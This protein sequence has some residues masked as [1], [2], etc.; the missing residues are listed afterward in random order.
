M[1]RFSSRSI[2]L[3]F[4]SAAIVAM[5]TP[6]SAAEITTGSLIGTVLDAAGK[7]LAKVTVSA[8][9][10]SGNYRTVTNE[11]GEFS[12]L[13][14]TPDTYTLSAELQ[15]YQ[16]GTLAGVNVLTGQVQ[17][18]AFRLTSG[19]RTIGKTRAEARA[20]SIGSTADAFIVTGA[21]AQARSPVSVSS[22]LSTFSAGTVQGS[23]ASAPGI[24]FDGLGNV[25]TRGGKVDDTVFTFDSVPIPQ[26]LTVNPGG[27]FVGAQTPTTGV[28][29][30]SV[31]L[32]GYGNQS[33]NALGGIV[34]Q[35][36]LVGTYPTQTDVELGLGADVLYHFASLQVRTASPDLR[37]R[38]AISTRFDDE[39]FSFGDG[40]SFYPGE[41]SVVGI[42]LQQRGQYSSVLNYHYALGKRDD[43]SFLE[44]NGAASY[45]QYGSPFAG[46]TIGLL[47]GTNADGTTIPFPGST[48]QNAPVT[49]PSRTRGFFN[50]LKAEY[51][52]TSDHSLE[53]LRVYQSFFGAAA[54]GPFWDDNAF[55]QGAVSLVSHNSGHLTGVQF[56]GT[57]TNDRNNVQYGVEHRVDTSILDEFVPTG[58]EAVHS[59]PTLQTT[60]GYF[61]DTWQ[62]TDRLALTGNGRVFTTH[63][64]P[65][66]GFAYDVGA[67]DPHFG[68]SY[69]LG[70]VYALRGTFDHNTVAPKPLETDLTDSTNVLAD[71]TLA[72]FTPLTPERSNDFTYSFEGGGRT[73]FRLTYYQ[74]FE[75]DRI[76]AIPPD[77]RTA[78]QNGLTPSSAGIPGNVGNLRANGFEFYA[79]NGPL[80]L[81][82]NLV[83]AYSS[84]SSEFSFN[85]LNTAA[86]LA[87]HLFPVSYLPNLSTTLS[88]E[89]HAGSH[90]R[91][92]PEM[93][94]ES[95]YPY[96]VGKKIWIINP[97]D[98]KTPIL[99]NNDNNV[100]PGTNYYFLRDPS[101]PFDAASN[102]YIANLGTPEGDDPNSIRTPAQILMNLHVEGDLAPRLTAVVDVVNLFGNFSP[103]QL[104]S[105]PYLVGPP[106]YK[107][108]NATYAAYYGAAAGYAA[109]YTL[110]NGIPTNDGVNQ[111]LPWRYGTAGYVGESWAAGRSIQV[112][113]RY[114]L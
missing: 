90:L 30:T 49:S 110:G 53:R 47:D 21:A 113:L 81:N 75:K 83:R 89:F 13:G 46:Q 103:S 48:N 102:P 93:T 100:N 22:G 20:F 99:V 64:K 38:L 31:T 12:L 92:T 14:V 28:D 96:G 114:R 71:G 101:M 15:G 39:Y 105:N 27:N 59:N 55:G 36:P 65:S 34:N 107:G 74:K 97:A 112:R 45:D 2:A 9:S 66:R 17:R 1:Y 44:L 32:A 108:G 16:S 69:R 8:A 63:V 86:L 33:D 77:L 82:G 11:R 42:G 26:G 109:P 3:V 68:L 61:G 91:I 98:N 37:S 19:L 85:G 79:K 6:T 94:Y 41:A 104:V 23:A 95:G 57:L 54:N 52:H 25:S 84:S 62:A 10:P 40:K 51:A 88:Y 73:Q 58:D 78:V 35:V 67:L 29:E 87:G 18:T 43:L 106:G 50:V 70:S 60:L 7:P 24:G 111:I 80:T 76:D 4:T 72:P 5:S 56:D